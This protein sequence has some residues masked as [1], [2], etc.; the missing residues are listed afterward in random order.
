M[1]RARYRGRGG[2]SPGRFCQPGRPCVRASGGEAAPVSCAVPEGSD[3][4]GTAAG[5]RIDD[6]NLRA[7]AGAAQGALMSDLLE[8]DGERLLTAVRALLARKGVVTAEEIAERRAATDN[9]SPGQ[10]AK[11]VAKAWLE[12]EFKAL[13]LGDG[14]KAAEALNIPMRGMP[15][16][17][18]LEQ[19]PKVHN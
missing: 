17:G 4:A 2:P 14:T 19:T 7:L 6:R 8:T 18:V 16:L 5:R 10:G 11:M 12:P 3:L 15:P 9:A 1:V 13:M